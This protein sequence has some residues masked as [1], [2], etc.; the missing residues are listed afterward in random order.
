MAASAVANATLSQSA[1]SSSTNGLVFSISPC[2]KQPKSNNND[3]DEKHVLTLAPFTKPPKISFGQVKVNEIVE[4]Y[5]LIINPQQFKVDLNI[6]NQ[7]LNLNNYPMSLEANQSANLKISWQ[8]DKPD[9]YKY[10]ILF[11][12]TNNAK[13]KFIVHAYGICLKP[14][15]KK[16]VRKPFSTLQPIRKEPIQQKAAK[17]KEA[18]ITTIKASMTSVNITTVNLVCD[19]TIVIDDKENGSSACQNS[20]NAPCV[21]DFTGNQT[22]ILAKSALNNNAA[23]FN[24]DN[25]VD[26]T[27]KPSHSTISR[28]LQHDEGS[29]TPKLA[30]YLKPN[31]EYEASSSTNFMDIIY[32]QT[33]HKMDMTRQIN[34]LNVAKVV[35]NNYRSASCDEFLK[36]PNFDSINYKKQVIIFFCFTRFIFI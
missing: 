33:A 9:N 10:T 13:L 20:T 26:L 17:E 32:S 25:N 4:R 14:E 3:D 15:P 8:P 35:E 11:E 19:K 21:L 12:V 5:V 6:V 24:D 29:A 28:T 27:P 22:T 7:A 16:A 36:T 34:V 18:N 23:R 2:K 31:S 30:E 1:A